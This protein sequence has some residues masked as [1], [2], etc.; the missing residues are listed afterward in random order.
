MNEL[1][2]IAEE[3]MLELK[4][5]YVGTEHFFLAYLKK[6]K[7]EYIDYETFKKYVIDIIG[8]SYKASDYVLYTP[9]LRDIKKNCNNIYEAMI[10]ILTEDDCIAYNILLTKE[11]NI[12]AIYLN[13]LNTNY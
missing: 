9:I 4:H 11:E 12:E 7:N 10:R 2:E 13:V 6:Y 1:F 3:E 5:P 8:S